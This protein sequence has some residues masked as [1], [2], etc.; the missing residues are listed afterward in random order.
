VEEIGQRQ[1]AILHKLDIMDKKF[2]V[3]FRDIYGIDIIV[4]DLEDIKHNPMVAVE[5]TQAFEDTPS[6]P[7]LIDEDPKEQGD[8]K[9]WQK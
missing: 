9:Q 8:I 3:L 6:N 4:A 5:P 1:Q 2:E 7:I